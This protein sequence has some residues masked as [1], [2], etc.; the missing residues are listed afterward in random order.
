MTS[1]SRVVNDS[2]G[3]QIQPINDVN[4]HS[5]HTTISS[6]IPYIQKPPLRPTN[7]I[8]ILSELFISYIAHDVWSVIGVGFVQLLF[9]KNV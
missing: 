2:T 9:K 4:C 5:K 7:L 1:D 6:L 8:T 3:T